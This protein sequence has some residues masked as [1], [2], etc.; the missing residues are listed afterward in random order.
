MEFKDIASLSGKNGLFLVVKPT[1]N[2]VILESLDI[3]K[4]RIVT[5]PNSK[6]SI[7]GDISIYL[8]DSKDNLPLEE[9]MFKVKE[10]YNDQLPI[11][12]KSDPEKLKKFMGE[13]LPNYDKEKVYVSDIKKLVLWY[14]IILKEAPSVLVKKVETTKENESTSI[15]QELPHVITEE[16]PVKPSPKSKTSKAEPLIP[17]HQT[18]VDLGGKMVSFGGFMMPLKYRSETEEHLAVRNSVGIFDVSHMGEFTVKGKE[19]LQFLEYLTSNSVSSL[20]NGKAQYS[21]LLNENGGIVDDLLVYKKADNDYFLVVNASNIEKDFNHMM[22]HKKFDCELVNESSS[23]CLFA[24]QGPKALNLVQKLSSNN[25]SGISYYNFEISNL[26]DIPNVIISH[27]GYTGSGGFELF[28][29]VKDAKKLWEL[30]FSVGYEFNLIP[31]GLGARDTLR[32]E[33]GYTL[34]GNDI[35]DETTPLEANLG[36]ITKLNKDFL[37]K[38]ILQAQKENGIIKKLVGFKML[39]IGIPRSHYLIY[40]SNGDTIGEVSSGTQSPLLKSGIGMG[41]INIENSKINSEIWI[42]IRDK[43]VK[44]I[45]VKT[46]FV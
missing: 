45:I 37:G 5:S 20:Q 36:W 11:D 28:V 12:S 33:K 35:N 16:K 25:L 9:V 15:V 8:E 7:L 27:T 10:K 14:S 29:Q 30:L 6:L 43:K 31:I 1:R 32:I 38:H 26:A 34:Y 13:L 44:A 2:G 23:W 39:E 19:S 18:H 4:K 24:V 42:G 40:N 17:L 3:E 22:K 21:C 46:P 41:Y